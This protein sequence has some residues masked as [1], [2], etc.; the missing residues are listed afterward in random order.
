MDFLHATLIF[1]V[2]FII[3]AACF[4]HVIANWGI[5][6]TFVRKNAFVIITACLDIIGVI[7]LPLLF[8]ILIIFLAIVFIVGIIMNAKDSKR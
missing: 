1:G 6:K 4:D 2:L 8:C 3:N 5:R 7:F